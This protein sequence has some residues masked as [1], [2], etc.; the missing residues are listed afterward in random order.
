MV[1][2]L[3]EQAELGLRQAHLG[4]RLE[5]D[6]LLT[7]KLD[8]AEPL[9]L[10]RRV[11]VQLDPSQ[12]GPNTRRQ[13]LGDDGLGDVVV[14]SGLEAGN[15]IVGIGLGGDDDDGSDALGSQ[16]PAHVE[17]RDVGKPKIE[18][19]EVEF[20][21][22]E[23][24]QTAG[25]VGRLGDVVTL[26]LER[27]RQGEADVIVILD[28][29]QRVHV[30]SSLAPGCNTWHVFHRPRLPL[31]TKVSVFFGLLALV[32]TVTL[33]VVTYTF[34]RRTLLEERENEA[35]QQAIS[36]AREVLRLL[37]AGAADFGNRFD[38]R[39]QPADDDGFNYALPEDGRPVASNLSAPDAF[40]PTLRSA[41]ED[42]TAGMQ[43]FRFEG[44]VFLG[45]GIPLADVGAA[46]YEAFP[47]DDTE[48]TLRVLL[49]SLVIGS[50][51]IT[52][53]AAGVGV[54]TSRR[55]LRPLDRI[56][57]AAGQIAAGDLDTR[58]APEW[59]PDLAPIVDSF[60]AMADAVQAR[61]EREARSASDV[62]HELRTPITALAAA[63][64]V[65]EVRRDEMPERARQAVDVIVSQIRRFDGMVLDLLELSRI[66]AG[67]AD[68]HLETLAIA[69]LCRRIAGH[70]GLAAVP[71][72]VDPN[73]PTAARVDRVRF[74][75]VLANLL[76]NADQHAGGP[77]RI[78]VEEGEPG[79]VLVAVE[80]AGPGVAD[81]E[82]E[83]I[84]ERFTRGSESRHRV[85]TGL[86]L[87]L[88]VEHAVALG[89]AAWV[90]DR[91]GGGARFVVQLRAGEESPEHEDGDEGLP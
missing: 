91:P 53:L 80:D 63:T 74:E 71:I 89:G 42:G 21:L 39:V 60:N 24:G 61:V 23:Q 16:G 30:G 27:H 14:R 5:H 50:A 73:A 36:N 54:W 33:S 86:G 43:R 41:V 9:C 72:D 88:V 3:V 87:A 35:Q 64:E 67:A 6:P 26:V 29:Q 31:R 4:A 82:K 17:A 58:V 1:G 85:G 7:A 52:L 56:T 10:G 65:L 18:E 69:E 57:V 22:V 40:P 44:D 2:E 68:L 25:T 45:V 48:Q 79:F 28:E 15:E 55:L 90:E 75:R 38:E 76:A 11:L 78:A 12:M 62:S 59:D 8:V 66:D 32:T 37:S 84:F 51:V 83:Q 19:H 77:V 13:L 49:L 34:A 46:Y 20:A 70:A 47:I 81:D